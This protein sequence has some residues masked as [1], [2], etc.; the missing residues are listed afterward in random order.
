[1]KWTIAFLILLGIIAS[2]CVILLVNAFRANTSLRKGHGEVT[3]I[4]A[5]RDLPAMSVLTSDMIEFSTST[6]KEAP[7]GYYSSSTQVVGKILSMPIVKGQPLTRSS[8]ISEGT[9]AQLAAALPSGMRAVS[10]SLS[11]QNV[12]G[13]LLYPGCVVDVL[14]SFKLTGGSRDVDS[15]G[16]ALSTTLLHAV[17]VLAIAGDSVVSKQAVPGEKDS[18]PTLRSNQRLNVTLLVNPKQAEALQLATDNGTISLA[19]RNPL[20]TAPVNAEATVLSRGKLS[21]LGALLGTTVK[22]S[23]PGGNEIADLSGDL[24]VGNPGDGRSGEPSQWGV[25]VIRGSKV[26]EEAIRTE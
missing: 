9:G 18:S 14:A 19:M 25:T 24:T 10:V 3:V 4:L 1:M 26:V 11:G 21:R 8:F 5:A 22:S 16:E 13:G 20:D 2:F 6:S 12:S 7:V 15:Q 17:Q 23:A